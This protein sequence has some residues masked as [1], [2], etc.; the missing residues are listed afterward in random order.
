MQLGD[1]L[2]VV[3]KDIMLTFAEDELISMALL[4]SLDARIAVDMPDRTATMIV[5][6]NA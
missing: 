4:V 5:S 3:V 6:D 1:A 2:E